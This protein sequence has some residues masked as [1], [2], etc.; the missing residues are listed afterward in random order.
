[1]TGLQSHPYRKDHGGFVLAGMFIVLFL[2]LILILI[3]PFMFGGW[4]LLAAVLIGLAFLAHRHL[5]HR[6]P[7]GKALYNPLP[8]RSPFGPRRIDDLEKAVAWIFVL[9]VVV[10]AMMAIGDAL[11]AYGLR[12]DSASVPLIGGAFVMV[13]NSILFGL[14]DSFRWPM[15]VDYYS[16]VDTTDDH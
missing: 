14:F 8:Q 13:A 3:L 6:G 11:Y 1:M 5:R 12:L 7:R 9:T 10:V 15:N 4:A 2:Y 16:T